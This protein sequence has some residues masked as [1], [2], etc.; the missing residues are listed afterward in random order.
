MGVVRRYPVKQLRGQNR[1]MIVRVLK[2]T[3]L[4]GEIIVNDNG[5]MDVRSVTWDDYWNPFSAG[6]ERVSGRLEALRESR[7]AFIE[8]Q[9]NLALARKYCFDY[10]SLLSLVIERVVAGASDRRLL[11]PLLSLECFS[12]RRAEEGA[13]SVAAATSNI[14]NPV[15]LLAKLRYPQ[16]YDDP[17]FVPLIIGSPHADSLFYHYR[18]LV[19]ESRSKTS[20]LIYPAVEIS[21]RAESFRCIELATF[22]LAAKTDPRAVRR[23]NWLADH[24]I[25]PFFRGLRSQQPDEKSRSFAIGDLGG[26]SGYLT[27]CIWSRLVQNHSDIIGSRPLF[28][29][30]VDLKPH[31]TARLVRQRKFL[32][33]LTEL[34]CIR[35]DWKDWTTRSI[36]ASPP[37]RFHVLL[38]CRLFNNF[39]K[40]SIEWIDDWYQVRM[41]AKKQLSS[42]DWKNQSYLPQVCLAQGGAGASSLLASNARTR[43]GR[44]SCF[45]QHSLS[46]YFRGIFLLS[47]PAAMEAGDNAVYFS[48]RRFDDGSLLLSDGRSA[49]SALC[50]LSDLVVIE[51]VDCT[52]RSL[53]RHME[54]NHLSDL[55]ASDATDRVNMQGTNLLCVSVRS[56][57]QFLPG[58]RIW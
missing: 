27:Q 52:G 42:R 18:Q 41:L 45:V 44:A 53:S 48:A 2:S 54:A 36:S 5:R 39:S 1:R 14:R 25:A 9:F 22:C 49:L 31:N 21:D 12:I 34:R 46:D 50:S 11:S 55:A 40:F 8:G 4:L 7:A 32:R 15:Y 37:P 19:I 57:E 38:L 47:G 26:G 33:N 24:A 16:A 58:R 28:W 23:A 56:N 6:D 29:H 3:D 13:S 35:S 10:F 43:L 20:L 30:L 51:D 17:K